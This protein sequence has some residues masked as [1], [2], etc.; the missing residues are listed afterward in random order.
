MWSFVTANEYNTSFFLVDQAKVPGLL[1]ES[2]SS[3]THHTQSAKCCSLTSEHTPALCTPTSS[4]GTMLV[5]AAH[6][7]YLGL[8]QGCLAGLPVSLCS[9]V[10]AAD[11]TIPIHLRPF[12]Q[13]HSRLFL[14]FADHRVTIR[15]LHLPSPLSCLLPLS[16]TEL[17]PCWPSNTPSTIPL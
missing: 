14:T 12:A 11:R 3:L 16:D 7:S 17:A 8:C 1:P 9:L 6:T 13:N 10:P 15:P 4:S 5:Q 2:P